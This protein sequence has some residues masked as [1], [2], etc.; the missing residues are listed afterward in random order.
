MLTTMGS[1]LVLTIKE[2]VNFV[3]LFCGHSLKILRSHVHAIFKNIWKQWKFENKW[4]LFAF[5]YI[6]NDISPVSLSFAWEHFYLVIYRNVLRC[7]IFC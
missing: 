4:S 6:Y 5:K 2:Y 1:I 3:R 7:R